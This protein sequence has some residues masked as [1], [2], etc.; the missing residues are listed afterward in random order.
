MEAL[1]QRKF[2]RRFEVLVKMVEEEKDLNLRIDV[3]TLLNTLVSSPNEV[4]EFTI[5]LFG[6]IVGSHA[7]L[8]QVERRVKIRYELEDLNYPKI[9]K[10]TEEYI[11]KAKGDG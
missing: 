5:T 8:Y 3:A 4:T 1:A 6:G 9:L 10:A 7:N 11:A 2:N